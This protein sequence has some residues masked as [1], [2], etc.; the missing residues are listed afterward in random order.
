MFRATD[1][2]WAATV[3]ADADLAREILGPNGER[4]LAIERDT[5]ANVVSPR[6]GPLF[7]GPADLGVRPALG[8]ILVRSPDPAAVALARAKLESLADAALDGPTLPHT[9]FVGFPLCLRD[10]TVSNAIRAIRAETLAAA[11]PSE[12][13]HASAFVEPG[14]ANIQ[15]C[16]LKLCSDE[17]RR[18]ARSATE[19]ARRAAT[20]A[21]R[22]DTEG[23]TEGG[24]EGGAEGAEE[25]HPPPL[26]ARVAGVRCARGDDDADP[27]DV[28]VVYFD[29]RDPDEDPNAKGRLTRVCEAIVG[30]YRD[31]GLLS[32]RD[33]AAVRPRCVVMDSRDGGF[34][35]GGFDATFDA[36]EITRRS[37]GADCGVAVLDEVHLS[38]LGEFDVAL[39][40]YYRCE[41]SAKLS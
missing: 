21:M 40:G 38:K 31:A 4:V 41:A 22:T 1:G 25:R 27:S 37:G 11:S 39:G 35:R 7:Q 13:I 18:A 17:R 5:G 28:D 29:A 32:R 14:R 2:Q 30:A 23:G 16:A 20:L 26:R 8:E 24:A 3:S 9:H 12:H 33:D 10:G 6:D 19:A 15:L 36:T 34:E